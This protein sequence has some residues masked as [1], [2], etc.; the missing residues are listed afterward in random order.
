TISK[1]PNDV[2]PIDRTGDGNTSDAINP[3]HTYTQAGIFNV[4]FSSTSPIGCASTLTLFNYITVDS[5]PIAS[6]TWAGAQDSCIA[7]PINYDDLSIAG[8]APISN[9]TWDFGDGSPFSNEVNPIYQFNAAGIFDVTLTVEDL[10]GCVDDTTQTIVWAPAPILDVTPDDPWGCTPHTVF[11]ENNSFPINGYDIFWDFGNGIRDTATVSP[12]TT[13]ELQGLYDVT[14]TIISPLGCE[15]METFDGMIKVDTVPTAQFDW[16]Y[17][18]C[19]VGW[20]NFTDLSIE[21]DGRIVDWIWDFGDG[22]TSDFQSPYHDYDT[23]GLYDV[24]LIVT[25]FNLCADTISQEVL[26][27][28]PADID[29]DVDDY[30]GCNPHPVTFINN[31]TPREEYTAFWNFG[32]DTTSEAWEPSHV[33]ADP[34]DYDVTISVNNPINCLVTET[35]EDMVRITPPPVSDFV[36]NPNNPTNFDP[37]VTFTELS[38]HADIWLW[39]FGNGD[40]SSEMDPVYS[41][42]DTGIYPVTLVVGQLSGCTDS[43]TQFVDVSPLFTYFLPNAFTPNDDQLNDEFRGTGLVETISSFEMLIW[44]RWG[45]A[46]FQTSNPNEGWNGRKNNSGNDSPQGVY[47]YTVKILSGRGEEFTYEGFVTLVR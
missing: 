33:Y 28:P 1:V 13:Y 29:I 30:L 18:N 8:G 31:T 9:W 19:Q 27:Y 39:D 23:A 14:L 25:D 34:G 7:G 46:V 22:N 36:F 37:E 47:V 2:I 3:T 41:Y 42:P 44:N 40:I 6:Y 35:V 4:T 43:L 21:N 24:S 26:W 16:N 11:F 45:E 5:I 17:E 20:T 38:E 15:S 32:D 10:N 12:T